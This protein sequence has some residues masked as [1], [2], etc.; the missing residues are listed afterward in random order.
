QPSSSGRARRKPSSSRT[1]TPSRPA[2]HR[3]VSRAVPGRHV[4]GALHCRPGHL[5]C[6]PGRGSPHPLLPRRPR[7]RVLLRDH[8]PARAPLPA[9]P[10]GA[11]LVR[12]GRQGGGAR[13]GG[14]V[15]RAA[16]HR[17]D[18]GAARRAARDA[19]APLRARLVGP[20]LAL[21]VLAAFAALGRWVLRVPYWLA[22]GI[23]TGL[24]AIVPFFGTLVSTLLPALFVLGTGNWLQALAVAAWGVAVHFVE[25]NLIAPLI[26]EKKV[27]L[28][29]VLT[30]ASVLVMGT[31][32]G[33]I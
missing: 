32:L 14:R 28:P 22:F 25:A 19:G 23:F 3:D 13:R 17:L 10:M 7:R 31:L 33:A 21:V 24:V 30:I 15:G 5:V 4:R 16:G 20:L 2:E 1:T 11:P 26:M 27:A 12:G 9:A 6:P 29:P 18:A 8:R